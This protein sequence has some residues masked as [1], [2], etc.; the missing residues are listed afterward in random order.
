MQI[1]GLKIS[2]INA[3]SIITVCNGPIGRAVTNFAV[4]ESI[5]VLI[6][7]GYAVK[8]F[9]GKRSWLLIVCYAAQ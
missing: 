6:H 8:L 4:S 5:F 2:D 7:K 3:N 1:T 9:V